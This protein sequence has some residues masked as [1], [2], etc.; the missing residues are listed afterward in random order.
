MNERVITILGGTGFVGRY[1]VKQLARC[2]YRLRIISRKSG[3]A[4]DI[5]TFG[6]T[7]QITIISGNIN[8]PES[9]KQALKGAYA[10]VN[11]VGILFEKGSQNF[12]DVQAIGA[13]KLAIAAKAAKVERFIH[14][15]ALGVEH[16]A[17]ANYARTKLLGEKAILASF[18]DA[19]ILR[20]SIIFGA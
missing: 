6:D 17:G 8:E 20:P 15:S 14:I 9:Y 16:E 13:E 12:S 11:L 4:S 2:G 5:R 3:I 18:T 19:T 1:V 7:G 10:V